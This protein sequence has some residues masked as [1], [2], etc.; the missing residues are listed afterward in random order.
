M[1]WAI[2]TRKWQLGCHGSLPG[3][4]LLAMKPGRPERTVAKTVIYISSIA[5]EGVRA[6]NTTLTQ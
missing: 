4:L 1:Y 2:L 6:V 5:K 3:C